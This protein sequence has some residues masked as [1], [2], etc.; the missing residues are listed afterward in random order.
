MRKLA[1]TVTLVTTHE[2]GVSHG[3]TATAVSS[4]SADPPSLL[5]CINRAAS[6]HGPTSRSRWFCVN[7]MAAEQAD[8]CRAFAGRFGRER[9][10]VGDWREG[11]HGLPYE[12]GAAA[13][14]F[15]GVD[16]E[17]HYGT[18]TVFIG[19]I[20]QLTVR[21]EASPLVFQAG[22]MGRFSAGEAPAR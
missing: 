4:L 1:A 12:A 5:V 17:L 11:P 21:E 3:M 9:F 22:A 18:H 2:D 13:V 7:L 14:L 15:C 19:R 20:E 6:M 16:E 8:L 10:D